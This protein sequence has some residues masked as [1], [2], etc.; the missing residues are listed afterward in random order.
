MI[1]QP[2]TVNNVSDE[3]AITMSEM[4][5]IIS[6][7]QPQQEVHLPYA[8][9]QCTHGVKRAGCHHNLSTG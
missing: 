8:C 9:Q 2:G 5:G 4:K 3:M 7:V 1:R 6:T